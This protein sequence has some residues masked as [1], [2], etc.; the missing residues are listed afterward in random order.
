MK[1]IKYNMKLF[2]INININNK[3]NREEKAWSKILNNNH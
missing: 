3:E 2:N 1:I